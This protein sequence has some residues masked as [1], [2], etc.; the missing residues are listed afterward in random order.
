[1]TANGWLQIA[2]FSLAVLLVAKPLGLYLVHVYDGTAT[3]LGPVERVIYRACGVN[4]AQDQHWTRYASAMLL[5]SGASMLLMFAP[6]GPREDYFETLARGE[7]MS[8]QQRTEFM[9]R[10]DTFGV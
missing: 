1:M 2:L 9:L 7:Q 3:W 8:E 5:F 6:G 10:H 4:P